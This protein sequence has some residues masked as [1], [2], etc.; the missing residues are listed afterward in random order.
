MLTFFVVRNVFL[1]VNARVKNLRLYHDRF[2]IYNFQFIFHCQPTILSLLG[3][4][5]KKTDVILQGGDWCKT[6]NISWPVDLV[7]LKLFRT[8]HVVSEV[9]SQG[10]T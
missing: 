10:K 1:Q 8:E 3:S 4:F 2:L 6:F 7:H 5:L 9:G